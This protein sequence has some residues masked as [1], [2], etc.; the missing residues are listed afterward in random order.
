MIIEIDGHGRETYVMHQNH[1]ALS[2]KFVDQQEKR[3]T[4]PTAEQTVPTPAAK[5]GP[6]SFEGEVFTL[7]YN[8]ETSHYDLAFEGKQYPI[9]F[10]A[11]E[12]FGALINPLAAGM[13]HKS[14][15][16]TFKLEFEEDRLSL[17]TNDDSADAEAALT[18]SVTV[19]FDSPIKEWIRV[20]LELPVEKALRTK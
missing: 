5:R 7:V 12:A 13:K 3:M 4:T 1:G 15:R 20:L 14:G 2:I 17:I 11:P 16:H 8:P 19:R 18:R 9:R 6:R 10:Q